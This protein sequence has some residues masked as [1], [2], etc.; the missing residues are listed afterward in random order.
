MGSDDVPK[1]THTQDTSAY[2][3][4]DQKKYALLHWTKQ[5]IHIV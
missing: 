1:D 4:R 3:Q 2:R 5:N